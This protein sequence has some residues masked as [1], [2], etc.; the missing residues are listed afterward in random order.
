[1]ALSGVLALAT[2]CKVSIGGP[3]GGSS[4]PAPPATTTA[5]AADPTTAPPASD[6][7][8]TPELTAARAQIVAL[9]NA[10]VALRCNAGEAQTAADQEVCT[11][12]RAA[13]TVAVLPKEP[14]P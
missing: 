10:R 4:G 1:M 6:P 5:P 13:M 8:V 7:E 3:P 2:A 14:R 9:L 12:A 11:A